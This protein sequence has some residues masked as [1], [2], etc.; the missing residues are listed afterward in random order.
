MATLDAR[1]DTITLAVLARAPQPGKAKTRLI[2]RLGAEGAAA[3]HAACVNRTMR[4]A[5]EACTQTALWCEPHPEHPFFDAWR[6]SAGVRLYAQSAGDLGARMHAA[7]LEHCRTRPTLLIGTDCPELSVEVLVEASL[8]LMSTDA[9]IIPAEDGGYVL[10]GLRQPQARLFTDIP[11]GTERVMTVTQ[12]RMTEL[13][14]RYACL[15]ELW[16]VDRPEDLDRIT[17]S[18]LLPTALGTG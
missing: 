18:E 2:Q 9:V 15:P 16:D 12:E 8:L 4:I 11:W 14:L 13:H 3:F 7:F 6:T 17:Q 5:M 10:V 1:L